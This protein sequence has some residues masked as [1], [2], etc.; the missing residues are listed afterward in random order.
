M[1]KMNAIV[2]RAGEKPLY[3]KEITFK[4][5]Q[6]YC[7]GYVEAVSSMPDSFGAVAFCDEEGK[8]T[9]KRPNRGIYWKGELQDVICGTF[10]VVN[11]NEDEPLSAEQISMIMDYYKYPEV[12][13]KMGGQLVGIPDVRISKERLKEWQVSR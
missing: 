7:G 4:D 9:Q 5:I 3:V 1:E 13:L 10:C 6:R 11:D 12:F 2:V 8:L